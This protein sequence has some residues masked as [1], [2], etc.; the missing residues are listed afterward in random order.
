MLALQRPGQ[1]GGT[2][3]SRLLLGTPASSLEKIVCLLVHSSVRHLLLPGVLEVLLACGFLMSTLSVLSGLDLSRILEVSL[4]HGMLRVATLL[5]LISLVDKLL[6]Q[7]IVLPGRLVKLSLAHLGNDL[8]GLLR[9]EVRLV[10]L[11]VNVML[12]LSLGLV[13]VHLHGDVLLVLLEVMHALLVCLSGLSFAKLDVVDEVCLL[14][15]S[16]LFEPNK[17]LLVTS[18]CLQTCLVNYSHLITILIESNVPQRVVIHREGSLRL[19]E[20]GHVSVIT[21]RYSLAV[22]SL[23]D[24]AMEV[25]LSALL[26]GIA[27][28]LLDR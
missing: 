8:L 18:Q 20:H 19:E 28:W 26:R 7:G 4:V 22:Q 15:F 14:L 6:L 17:L 2:P 27:R 9:A 23:L 16:E 13:P 11:L 1:W 10:V 12:L 21:S 5:S 25:A 3:S 24:C